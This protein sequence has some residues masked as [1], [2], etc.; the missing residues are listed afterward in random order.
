[1][2]KKRVI[3]L[4]VAGIIILVMVFFFATPVQY[5]LPTDGKQARVAVIVHMGDI[6]ITGQRGEPSWDLKS[7]VKSYDI[8]E[9]SYGESVP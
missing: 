8:N 7:Q 4:I 1:M 9:K 5:P 6:E 3:A 2:G